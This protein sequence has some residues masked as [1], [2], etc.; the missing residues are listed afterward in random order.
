MRR[1]R[2]NLFPDNEIRSRPVDAGRHSEV[3]RKA[4]PA[5]DARAGF[6][7]PGL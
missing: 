4:G 7:M 1:K 3:L 2:A 6:P 5:S